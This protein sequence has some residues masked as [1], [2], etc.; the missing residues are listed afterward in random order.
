MFPDFLPAIASQLT[1]ATSIQLAQSIQ[2]TAIAT[3]F[4]PQPIQTTYVRMG[5]GQPPILLLHGFDSSVLEFRR[6]L[7]LLA[8]SRE[9]WAVDLLGF[10]FGDRVSGLTFSPTE[11]ETHLHAFW[12]NMIQCPVILVGASMGGAAAI[13]FTLKYP[14][15]VEKLVLLDSAG[16]AKPP[17]IAK[18]MFP[19]LDRLATGFLRNPRIR[20]NISRAAYFDKSLANKDAQVCATLHLE[21]LNWHEALAAFAKSGGYG[22]FVEQLSDLQQSTLIVWGEND[23]IL[24]VKD[25]PKFEK[26]IPKSQLVWM[27]NCG[28]VP[29]L[30][31]PQLTAEAILSF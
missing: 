9:T 22:S 10:G 5:T 30:E 6:L 24:G 27:P 16:L 3:P 2:Q 19:P 7:P 11:I 1:E 20:Q 23:Q 15:L 18:F 29:H 13:S 21:C 26:L 17:K 14:E 25:A 8:E 4:C 28:H 12:Q 31:Q